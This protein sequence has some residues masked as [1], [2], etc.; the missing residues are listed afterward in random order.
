MLY[1]VGCILYT[2]GCMLYTVGCILYAVY[3]MLYAVYCML[4]TVCYITS[5]VLC[6]KI[7]NSQYELSLWQYSP[8][9]STLLLRKFESVLNT[10]SQKPSPW[11]PS[12][13]IFRSR[14]SLKCPASKGLHTKILYEC[15]VSPTDTH[16]KHNFIVSFVPLR[17]QK[18]ASALWNTQNCLRF[19]TL[20]HCPC[21]FVSHYL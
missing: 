16:V 8:Q 13:F 17:R 1:T 15:V 21:H 2:V 12:L 5:Y 10:R 18:Q 11:Q 3:C 4:Y 20:R 9:L 14:L 19:A 6:I 7:C